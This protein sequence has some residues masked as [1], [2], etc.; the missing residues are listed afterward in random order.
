[1]LVLLGGCL[2]TRRSEAVSAPGAITVRGSVVGD[3][4]SLPAGTSIAENAGFFSEEPDPGH[5]IDTRVVDVTWRMLE[6]HPDDY[7]DDLTGGAEGDTFA[8]LADQLADPGPFWLRVWISNVDW[9]PAWVMQDCGL[10]PA[11]EDETGQAHLPVWDSC[12]W[13]HAF[14]L[15]RHLLVDLGLRHDP[16]LV[17]A[18]VPG[19]FAYA[20][21]DFDVVDQAVADGSLTFPVFDAWFRRM[22][23]DL[24]GVMGDATHKLVF[25]GEDYP[26]SSLG[27]G[28]DL[29]ARY[30]VT[31]GM[32][33]RNGISELSNFHLNQV[34]AYGTT[35]G[36]DGHLATDD[37]W[38]LSEPG[39]ISVAE[40]ECFRDCGY[41][42]AH[43]YYAVKQANL[44]ALAA[45][46]TNWL[47]VRP[48]ESYLD[49]YPEHWAWV[50]RSLGQHVDTSSDAW[51]ALR[52]ADD[53]FWADDDEAS[54]SGVDWAQRPH[55]RNL[56]RWVTQDD[57]GPGC[58]SR[59]GTEVHVGEIA[60]DNG[61]AS[62]GRRTDAARG[63]SHLCFRISDRFLDP[64]ETTTVDV[65]VTY[66]DRGLGAFRLVVPGVDGRLR[67]PEVAL[68]D[69]RER[70]TVTFR[71]RS[72]R[73]DGSLPGT[74]DFRIS[75][76]RGT[77]VDVQ[78]VRVVKPGGHS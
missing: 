40:H 26:F 56:E 39:R 62:E 64:G 33:V 31:H 45:F 42:A 55:V 71:A 27:A 34:P 18:Y 47:Y 20:E 24:T 50:R 74:S 5:H 63:E 41:H 46:R 17:M 30:A 19:A 25:A 53:T 78:F 1:M 52:R 43:L 32:G 28:D 10:E 75:H 68:R 57:V 73:F 8:S 2:S 22:V 51:V 7:R 37:D 13:G 9:A 38:Q 72:A 54:T 44:H 69:T 65:K 49:R 67:S 6:P 77:D 58:R 48:I 66:V 61:T 21:F 70:R 14:D 3:D 59:R 35:I 60:P 29:Y 15:Y 4:W 23:E 12:L 16:R 36:A 76:V 11:G